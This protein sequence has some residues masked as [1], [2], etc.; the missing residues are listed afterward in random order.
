MILA[1]GLRPSTKGIV[2]Q[3]KFEH[4]DNDAKRD[5]FELKKKIKQLEVLSW[6]SSIK[7]FITRIEMSDQLQEKKF[8]L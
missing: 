7:H 6:K 4:S 8:K 1:D 5:A 2:Q 3:N